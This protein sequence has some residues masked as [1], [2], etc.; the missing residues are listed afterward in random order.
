MV[1]LVIP[2]LATA[3]SSTS[4]SNAVSLADTIGAPHAAASI[5][6][7]S[8]I[9]VLT[10]VSIPVFVEPVTPA[11]QASVGPLTFRRS[12][13]SFIVRNSGNTHFRIKSLRV[14]G[15]GPGTKAVFSKTARGWYVLAGGSR[16]YELAVPGADCSRVKPSEPLSGN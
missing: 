2:A 5:E 11:A 6:S 3:G 7:T 14:D 9:T 16:N 10:N 8:L 13:L 1:D 15:F 12:T 4:R